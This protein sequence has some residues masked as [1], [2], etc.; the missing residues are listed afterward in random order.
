M[1]SGSWGKEGGKRRGGGG[2]G[3]KER[4][5]GGVAVKSAQQK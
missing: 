4:R 3:G 1:M 2:E 5:Y